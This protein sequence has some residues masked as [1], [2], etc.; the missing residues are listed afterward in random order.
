MEHAT[1]AARG[2]STGRAYNDC[3][4]HAG[5]RKQKRAGGAHTA[6]DDSGTQEGHNRTNGQTREAK[7]FQ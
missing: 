1:T 4:A 2:Q 3:G 6:Q 5:A 7:P